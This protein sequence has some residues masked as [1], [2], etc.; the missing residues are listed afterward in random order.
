MLPDHTFRIQC[1]NPG[2]TEP[3]EFRLGN[4]KSK[5]VGLL[6]LLESLKLLPELLAPPCD[7]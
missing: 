3:I 5:P 7:G 1:M 4:Q 6:A 2:N